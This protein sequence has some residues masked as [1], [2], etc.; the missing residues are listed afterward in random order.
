[1]KHKVTF[2][3]DNVTIDVPD[4]TNLFKA[5]KAA[6]LYVLSSCGGK[7]NCGKCKVVIREGKI[8]SAGSRSFLTSEEAARGYALACISRVKSDLVVEIPPE[9][10]MQ[11]KHKIAVGANTEELIRL[12]KQTGGC[13]DSRISRIYLQISP[14]TID[15]NISD[16]ERLRRALD[17]AGFSA[18]NLHINYMTLSKL[19]AVLREGRWNVT[20]SVFSL[21]EVLEVLDIY[22][23]DATKHRYG[24]AVD[25]GTTTVVVYLVDMKNGRIVGTASSYN[26]Q[27]KCGDDVITRIVYATERNGLKELQSLVVDNIGD[28]LAELAEKNNV[29]PGMI[30]YIVIAGNTTMEHLFYGINPAHIREEPYIPT[31]AFFPLIRGKSI[32]FRIHPQAVIYSVPNVASY[33]GG[34]VTAGVL[35]SQLHRQDAISL[36]IDIGTNGEI[37]LGNKDWLVTAACS[38]G[39]AFEGSGIKFGM[40]AMEGAIE[41]VEIDPATYDVN[42]RVIGDVK[43]IGICGSGMIDALAEM[44]LK[45]VIDQKGKIR[46]EIGSK[47]IRRGESGLEYVL[48]W[49]VESAINKEIVITEVDLDN[50]IRAKAAIYAGFAT[51]LSHMGM[52]FAN[53]DKLYVAG[54]FGRYIDVERAISIGMLPDLPVDKF[55]F[56]GNTSIMGAYFSL[57]CDRLRHEAEEIATRMTYIELSVSRSFMDEYLSALF[58][59]HTD[60]NAFPS[61]REQMEARKNANLF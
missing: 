24:A 14:P 31:A 29:S 19:P 9:S 4:D 50:L 47:R 18:A 21:G 23:G 48:A 7:G 10:R 2:L 34:D 42:Y 15:D 55:Q 39:P 59:P 58:L 3:P 5:V 8:E 51:L 53:I 46:E 35:V 57:L 54:G 38:A 16:L 17:H 22:P 45:G 61:V 1:M 26:P 11:A 27:V 52:T 32:G 6:G 49:R 30:D 40:R 37:V 28:M 33:V 25:I 36:F 12:M 13:L 44:Y 60:M 56:L 43:P 41:E 20:A